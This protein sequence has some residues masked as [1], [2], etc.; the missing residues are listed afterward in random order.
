VSAHQILFLNNF[1][2][3]F[4]FRMK[5]LL[6][7]LLLVLSV[8]GI[9]LAQRTVM[10][11]VSGDDGEVLIGATV[12]VKGATRGTRT[13][14]NGKYSVEVPSGA[15]TL[16]FSY[17]GFQTQEIALGA[18]NVLDVVMTG[19]AQLEEVVVTAL[20]IKRD[21]KALGYAATVVNASE[22][23]EKPETDV[24][25]ALA[26]KSPGILI[27]NSAGLAGSGTK[28]NIRG[29]ST[30]SGNSQ[31]L[32][33]VDGVP[34]NTSANENNNFNDGNIT[35]TRNLDIDPNNIESISV[36]RGLSATTLY[37]A[38]GRNGVI[39]VTTKT[40]TASKRRYTASVSQSYHM[41]NAFVP[42]FQNKWA[43]GFD[44]DYGEFFSNWGSL[45]ANSKEGD[46]TGYRHPYYEH[47]ALFPDRPEFA[48]LNNYVPTAQPNN[49]K[50]FFQTGNSSTT[51]VNAGVSTEFGN[52]NVSFSNTGEEGYIAN[53]NLNR[54]N[55]SIGGLANIS[56]KL[57][58][59][60]TFSYVKT[61]FK[62]PTVGAGLGSNSNGGPS[63]FANLFYTPRN[64][65]LMNWPYQNPLTGASVYYRN[66]NSITNPRW[67]LENSR[68]G[69]YV[70]RFFSQANVNY[71]LLNWLKLTYRLG[72]DT[73]NENQEYYVNKG[74]VGYVADVAVFANGLYRTTSGRNTIYDHSVIL[75]GGRN[76]TD[77]IDFTA[78][79]GV[80]GRQDD[81]RQQ[82]LES[83]NQVVYGLLEH[84][85]FID[86]NDRSLRGDNLNYFQRSLLLGAFADVTFG[87]K[88]GLYLN[89]Q[90]R[91]DWSGAHESDYRSLFYPGAS[92]SF[93]PTE[94]FP[95]LQSKTLNFL[96]LRVG[97]GTSANFARPY[98]T[99]PFL[100]L[101]SNSSVDALGNVIT[102]SLPS[103]LS[104]PDLRPELQ[105]E[106]E[107]GLEARLF[108]NRVGIDASF[109]SRIAED[110]IIPDNPLDPSTGYDVTAINAGSISN[111]GVELALSLTPVRTKNF[112]WNVKGAFTKNVSKV[113]EL[114]EGSE[115]ILISG[116][117]NLGNFAIEGQP[118]GVIKGTYAVRTGPDGRTG[119][120]KIT[121]NGDYE[122]S[123]ET[124]IIGDPNPDFLLNGFTDFNFK[125][126]TLSGQVE[127]VHG[128][129]IFSYSAATLV[130]RGVAKDLEEF[131][132][133]LPI[134]LPGVLADGRPNNIP[135]PASTVFF[136]NTIIGGG[137][138]DRGIFDAT[139][140]RIREV[141]LSYS[142][143][144]RLLGNSV[145]QGVDISVV[146]NNL[147]FR[148]VNTPKYS[149]VDADRVAFGTGN[150]F[151]FDFLG[152]PSAR[153]VGM[154]VKVSF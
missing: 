7:T 83:S 122:I 114:P 92:V 101:N 137:P 142:L 138:D 4:I 103:R 123:S 71:S 97:Y 56:S 54:T 14:I 89:L 84:R 96:K 15:T 26:G 53:N 88:N 100:T 132:P 27:Q 9:S 134:I 29:T 46:V 39:L 8:M 61:N 87:Y 47:R 104:N 16:V 64:M 3:K 81:Y 76:I 20:G 21:K 68:Q 121:N 117:T 120:Y 31:P 45:F 144:K 152:G 44:G 73:Y 70:D 32:W 24:A 126:F 50:D 37:G 60:A 113:E 42:E 22:I 51:S 52:F 63:V 105:R 154:N 118:Y 55:I 6:T 135:V 119:D 139:R 82:G 35:P 48:Q 116:F 75:S 12:S 94:L 5:R 80:N 148:A 49:V 112:T 57:S 90:G 146:G 41:V 98:L 74:S 69:S 145:V 34:I 62:S 136:G 91:N 143:P 30:I 102:L 147:W 59:G 36:L 33:I 65:D 141:A 93:I 67:L 17:T 43:N 77:A 13:D 58:I 140:I 130:G 131:N 99:R 28:I 127:Y 150:G 18:S 151:G 23:A 129:D 2:T 95:S 85:N 128:G 153:R 125:G 78:N 1:L 149:K 79:I 124:A 111:R 133:E 10:G 108:N 11:T 25:R 19:N 110:Q 107:V 109:Y 106:S 40:A 66:N 86:N 72:L 38:Q 115:E